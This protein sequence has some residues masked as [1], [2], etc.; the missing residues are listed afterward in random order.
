MKRINFFKFF[1][2]TQDNYPKLEMLLLQLQDLCCHCIQ[3]LIFLSV[4]CCPLELAV[5]CVPVC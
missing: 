1:W 5:N 2:M 3:I 4:I